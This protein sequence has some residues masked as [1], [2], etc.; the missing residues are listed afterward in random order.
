MKI[1]VLNCGSSSV[2]YTLFEMQSEKK[3]AWG[4]VECIGLQEAFYTRHVENIQGRKEVVKVSNHNQ[5]VELIIKDLLNKVISD[6]SEISVIGHRIVHGGDKFYKSVLVTN[7]VKKDLKNC[8]SMAPLHMGAHYA[9]IEAVE[10][11]LIGVPSVLV[12]DT[13]F[14]QTMPDYAYMYALPYEFFKKDHIRRYGFHGTS[15]SYVSQRA[16]EMLNKPLSEINLITAHLGA[17]S[18]IAAIKQGKVIDT[19]MGFTP[20]EGVMMATRCG[21]IDP[22]IITYII[23]KY[24]QYKDAVALNKLT[25]Q[26]SGLIGISGVSGDMRDILKAIERGNKRA[27]LAFEMLCHSIKKYIGAYFGILNGIDALV[28]T[29]GIGENSFPVRENVCK[30]LSVLGIEIDLHENARHSSSERFIS[31]ESSKVK[32][33]IIPTNEELMIARDSKAVLTNIQMTSYN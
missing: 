17:G 31:T 30:N 15:H 11:M 3:L 28:F 6:V 7:E 14:H 19:S 4:I 9:G 24:P 8:F 33:M 10:K 23:N 26:E 2:K 5:A 16:A 1:L 22:A 18:S 21:N 13:A 20:L 27:S 25:N 29:A 12:F 32:V